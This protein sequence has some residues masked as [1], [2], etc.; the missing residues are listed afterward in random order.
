MASQRD[1]VPSNGVTVGGRAT[2]RVS[3]GKKNKDGRENGAAYDA[4]TSAPFDPKLTYSPNEDL[5][6]LPGVDGV[7]QDGAY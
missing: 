2:E 4:Q 7:L 6:E 3:E 5:K 1:A